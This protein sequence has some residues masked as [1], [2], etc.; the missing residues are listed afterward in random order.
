MKIEDI[1]FNLVNW[2]NIQ[3]VEYPGEQGV[4]TWR[5]WEMG[6]L[7]VRMVEYSAG[8]LA[9]HWCSRGHVL[10][11]L[12]GELVTELEGGQSHPMTAG[13]SFQVADD[14]EPHRVY[15]EQGATVFIVD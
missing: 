13:M 11:V 7:R 12:A 6:N 14:A 15:T 9:D 1:P 5:T 4:S 2:G 8:Y 10:L 3:R